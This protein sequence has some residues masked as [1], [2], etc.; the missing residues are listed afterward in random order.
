MF[1]FYR[2]GEPMLHLLHCIGPMLHLVGERFGI[3]H[4]PLTPHKGDKADNHRPWPDNLCH[5]PS[6]KRSSSAFSLNPLPAG[7][8]LYLMH[9]SISFQPAVQK[10]DFVNL[11]QINLSPKIHNILAS[12]REDCPLW[13]GCFFAKVSN[14]PWPPPCPA[15]PATISEQKKYCRYSKNFYYGKYILCAAEWMKHF[16]WHHIPL[17]NPSPEFKLHSSPSLISGEGDKIEFSLHTSINPCS[18]H[19]KDSANCTQNL[20]IK[21]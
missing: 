18:W 16:C 10:F 6:A 2:V 1:S 11:W 19:D 3:C 7:P 14:C 20:Q 4:D 12:L 15:P 5:P 21:F 8:S 13:N 9:V 17:C